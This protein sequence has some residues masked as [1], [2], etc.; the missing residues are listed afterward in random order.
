MQRKTVETAVIDFGQAIGLLARR[1]RAASAL[2]DLSWTQAAVMARLATHGP[3]T[4]ADLAGAEHEPQLRIAT[5]AP[6]KDM[7]MVERKAHT[8]DGRQMNVGLTAKGVAVWKSV[9]DAKQ[10]WLAHA[11]A[12]LD[13]QDRETLFTAGEIIKRLVES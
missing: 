2:H 13:E 6:V 12:Q 4:T 10:T 7:G 5:M 8:T 11:I 1:L 3:A 9:K